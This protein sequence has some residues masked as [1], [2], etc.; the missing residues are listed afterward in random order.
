MSSD[1]DRQS[2]HS[3]FDAAQSS[4]GEVSEE[5]AEHREVDEQTPDIKLD[6]SACDNDENAIIKKGSSVSLETQSNDGKRTP[7]A[8]NSDSDTHVVK[9]VESK[10]HQEQ[11]SHDEVITDNESQLITKRDVE[12]KAMEQRTHTPEAV[13][14]DSDTHI[15]I[16]ERSEIHQEHESHNEVVTDDEIQP[17]TSLDVEKN[18]T[19]KLEISNENSKD[20]P[21]DKLSSPS[22]KE[23]EIPPELNGNGEE[24]DNSKTDSLKADMNVNDQSNV[25]FDAGI[26]EMKEKISTLSVEKAAL[27]QQVESALKQ[28]KL[29]EQNI[30][31]H[32][33][34]QHQLQEK[35]T[36]QMTAR[37]EVESKLKSSM[38]SAENLLSELESSKESL[39]NEELLRKQI[40]ED[41]TEKNK[42]LIDENKR[43][44]FELAKSRQRVETLETNAISLT[45]RL[46]EAKKIE[47]AKSRES[48]RISEKFA[49]L[50][51]D[52][53]A[54][55]NQNTKQETLHKG[56]SEKM[57]ILEESLDKERQLNISR[58][59]KMKSFVDQKARCVYYILAH[60]MSSDSYLQF[61]V[62]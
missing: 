22:K 2:G 31:E 37:A 19:N 56:T 53:I 38:A 55:K 25:E 44:A 1:D 42:I 46:N 10:I 50:E 41:L 6:Q 14:S 60:T 28:I 61:F 18:L 30:S 21:V 23:S 59:S 48:T 33:E 36:T 20:S 35:L 15:A 52:M 47:A 13:S 12:E 5:I 58:K 17:I 51:D 57:K 45:A 4:T 3:N 8:I 62:L 29:S 9:E 49:A 16:E 39:K 43:M 24:S 54:M 27:E 40:E 26:N 32:E 7:E 11:E 34:L